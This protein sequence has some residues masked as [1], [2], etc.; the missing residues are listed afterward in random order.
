[1]WFDCRLRDGEEA[2]IKYQPIVHLTQEQ[3]K[4]INKLGSN[5]KYHTFALI[6]LVE[7]VLCSKSH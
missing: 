7:I 5:Q 6:L 1:M 4:V 2:S 3:R